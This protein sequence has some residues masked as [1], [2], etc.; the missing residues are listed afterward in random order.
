MEEVK[1][2][3]VLTAKWKKGREPFLEM[4]NEITWQDGSRGTTDDYFEHMTKTCERINHEDGCVEMR[5]Y[6]ELIADVRFDAAAGNW[7]V[8]G[9]GV[10]PARLDL[11]ADAPDVLIRAELFKMPIVYRA[12]I[13]RGPDQDPARVLEI[14]RKVMFRPPMGG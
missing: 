2:T 11:D 13:Y 10:T 3:L 14:F 5:F 4:P 12:R 6:P 8:S 7:S 1:P 9:P